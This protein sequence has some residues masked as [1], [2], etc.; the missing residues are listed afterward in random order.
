MHLR[1]YRWSRHY[2]SAEA[3]LIELLRAKN[4]AAERWAAEE[5]EVLAERREPH[6]I[7]LWCA[8]GSITFTANGQT[9]RLQPGDTLDLPAGTAISATAGFTGAVCYESSSEK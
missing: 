3:E 1:K 4:I 5:Y 8:E 2:E 9:F 6:D 7:R